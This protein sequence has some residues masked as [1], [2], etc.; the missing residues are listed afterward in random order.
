MMNRDVKSFGR[1]A[2]G[3]TRQ[4]VTRRYTEQSSPIVIGPH[5]LIA[6]SCVLFPIAIGITVTVLYFNF[7]SY[8]L[9]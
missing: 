3:M 2:I 6:Y 8:Y 7:T 9:K 1:A 5:I 4:V